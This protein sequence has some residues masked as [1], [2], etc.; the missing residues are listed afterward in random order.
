L[1]QN[2]HHTPKNRL[3]AAFSQADRE[4]YFSDLDTVPLP[5]RR[6]FY[7]AGAPIEHV[8]FI[9]DGVGSILTNLANGSTVEVGMIGNEGM[10]GM[11]V[12]L[13]EET[14]AQHIVVQIPGTALRMSGS[15]CKRA[16]DES[17]AVRGIL[18]RSTAAWLNQSAQ[19]AACNR[20]HTIEKRCARWLLMSS[21]RIHSDTVPMTHEFLSSMLGVQRTGITSIA[22]MLG[23]AGLIRYRRGQVT[24]VDRTGLEATACECY[25]MDRD[26]LARQP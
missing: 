13:G 12:F 23:R 7:A 1:P 24:I 22:R 15:A 8:Y 11:P 2:P 20:V 19:T 6:V 18:L 26:R 10:I 3:L 21:D 4:Q 25:R 16:F 5:M 14:S 17:A 9:E